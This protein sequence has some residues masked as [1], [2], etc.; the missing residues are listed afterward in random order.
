MLI[1][2]NINHASDRKSMSP[3]STSKPAERITPTGQDQ[4][5]KSS[6]QDKILTQKM[7]HEKRIKSLEKLIELEKMKAQKLERIISQPESNNENKKSPTTSNIYDSIL[8]DVD[9]NDD[10]DLLPCRCY[11][12][13]SDVGGGG[14]GADRA[15][16][17]QQPRFVSTFNNE[18]NY[19]PTIEIQTKTE[20]LR[21][22]SQTDTTNKNM[23]GG[24]GSVGSLSS[25][26]TIPVVVEKKT[27]ESWFYSVDNPKFS[28]K[29]WLILY[30]K[31]QI[32]F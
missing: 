16:C 6:I 1:E 32:W 29:G 17:R 5:H 15:E 19:Q 13:C 9:D 25:S 3:T 23:S 21:P 20:P 12:C 4:Q 22:Q 10:D 18:T 11:C 14:V 2:S 27:T 28:S 8:N 26:R 30:Q 7:K 24:T 31:K